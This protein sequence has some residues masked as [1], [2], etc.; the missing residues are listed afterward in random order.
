MS[1]SVTRLTL[2][3]L[4]SSIDRDLRAIVREQLRPKLAESQL[5]SGQ[6]LERLRQRAI[7]DGC[8]GDYDDILEYLDFGDSLQALNQN[9]GSLDESV[10]RFLKNMSPLI[11]K[12]IPVRN[13]VMHARPLHVSDFPSVIDVSR[14]ILS[15]PQYLFSNL[16]LFDSETRKN[17][18]HI[19]SLDISEI[20]AASSSDAHNLPIPDFDETGFLGR[21]EEAK[22][23]L[24][25]C[26]SHWPVITVV[27]EGGVGKTALAL[28]VA[29]DLLDDTNANY[30]AIVWTSSK[31]TRLSGNDIVNIE[32]GNTD[33]LRNISRHTENNNWK[34]I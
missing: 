5:L 29:Y 1:Y 16:R 8:A 11:E 26:K 17:P 34:D 14:Q 23:L 7:Q 6:L 12:L 31:T 4:L 21:E 24:T 27:G 25:A 13:R 15:Y 33:K 22:R 20:D 3:G 19:F 28:R 32:G 10:K 9:K 18:L 30:D 2:Y